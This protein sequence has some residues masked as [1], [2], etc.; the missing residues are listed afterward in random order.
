MQDLL[1]SSNSATAD[2]IQEDDDDE[3]KKHLYAPR[4]TPLLI[5]ERKDN[6]HGL[7]HVPGMG[8]NASLGAKA[9][10]TGPRLAG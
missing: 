7:G 10:N 2:D 6:S 9:S 3:A 4:D 8:L 5:I 1:A